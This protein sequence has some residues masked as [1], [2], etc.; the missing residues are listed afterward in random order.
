MPNG[1]AC[2][3]RLFTKLLKPVYS[4]LRTQG[5]L[6]V[7]Y[8]D[9]TYLQGDHYN[10]CKQ[11]VTVTSS[12][13]SNLG[14]WVHEEKSTFMPSQTIEFL[15]FVLNSGNMT[16]CL[17]T[18]KKE[19]VKQ[20]CL[21]LLS[22]SQHTIRAVS[23]VIGL[24]VASFPGIELGPLYNRQL[25]N[26]KSVALKESKG[27]FDATMTISKTACLDLQWWVDNILTSFKQISRPKPAYVVSTDASMTGW[28]AFF[29]GAAAGGQW[30]PDEAINHINVLELTAVLLGLQTFCGH[31]TNTHICLQIDNT[32][33]VAYINNMGGS[34]SLGCNAKAREIWLWC[35]SR[36]IW[37]TAVHLP[38]HMNTEADLAS[39]SFHDQ[40]EWQLNPNTFKDIVKTLFKPEIDLFVSR[41]NFQIEPYV[42]W[43]PDLQAC[44]VDAFKFYTFPPFSLLDRVLQKIE[45]DQAT[46]ILIFPNWSTQPWFPRIQALELEEPLRLPYRKDILILPYKPETQHPLAH[47]LQLMA[48][49]LSG[50]P[51]K[52]WD[53]RQKR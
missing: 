36:H 15:G 45:Q 52:V 26:D 41:L 17:T 8:I 42:S 3:P 40:T 24:L 31:F 49:S 32:T 13:F 28:G 37:V 23:E 1:L 27:N 48:C 25:E 12:L 35:I 44:T 7:G 29:E 14:L 30:L 2:A 11:N 16:V 33:A 20:S 53:Y 10:D 47:K 4:S 46:G 22:Q 6:S 34:H 51:S 18:S 38:G 43:Q 9:D 39:R 50:N 21:K 5:L 19:K